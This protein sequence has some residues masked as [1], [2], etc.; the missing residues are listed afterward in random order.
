MQNFF[1]NEPHQSYYCLPG[2]VSLISPE[3]NVL[4]PNQVV[5]VVVV[6]VAESGPFP[7]V[8]SNILV[9]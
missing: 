3:M 9:F 7:S 8:T 4:P 5:V 6:C 2:W 1:N